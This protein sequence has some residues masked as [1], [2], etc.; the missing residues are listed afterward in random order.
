MSDRNPHPSFTLTESDAAYFDRIPA[1]FLNLLKL[2]HF[3][4][5]NSRE[6]EQQTRLSGNTIRSR[7]HRAREIIRRLRAEDEARNETWQAPTMGI[8]A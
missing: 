3:E 6:I 2:V 5:M 4:K 7:V 1:G 8:L